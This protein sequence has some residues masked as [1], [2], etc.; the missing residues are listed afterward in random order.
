[1]TYRGHTKFFQV[2]RRSSL[3]T[4]MVMSFSGNATS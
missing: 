1:M 3:N 4:S 2:V